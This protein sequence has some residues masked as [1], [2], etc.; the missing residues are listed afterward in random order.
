MVFCH[1][2]PL[3]WVGINYEIGNNSIRISAEVKAIWKTGVEMEAMAA[4]TGA[5]LN[6]YDMLKPLDD[7]SGK[8]NKQFLQDQEISVPV[9]EILPDEAD[10]I[11]NCLRQ[12]TDDDIDLVITTGGTGF[13]PRDITPEATARVIEKEAPSLVETI[14]RH[15]KER[16]P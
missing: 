13:G 7:T 2:L 14:R 11:V 15:G 5:L 10:R 16:T 1:T 8:R 4:V 9:Y 3:D 6:A 12:L